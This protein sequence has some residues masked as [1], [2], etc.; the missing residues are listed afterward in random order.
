VTPDIPN[1]VIEDED[2]IGRVSQLKYEDHDITYMMKFPKLA[3]HH[4][5]ELRIDPE[6]N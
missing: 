6:I 1:R 3:S 5:L 2:M 4:Y